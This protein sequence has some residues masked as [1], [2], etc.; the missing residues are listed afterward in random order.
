MGEHT[1]WLD[2]LPGFD[3]LQN[4]MKI[5]FGRTWSNSMFPP[6]KHFTIVPVFMS[7]IVF[8]IILAVS[9]AYR[10]SSENSKKLTP[11]TRISFISVT[12]LIIYNLRIIT[13]DI[14]GDEKLTKDIFP[15]I[16][17]LFLFILVGNFIGLIPGFMPPGSTLQLNLAMALTVFIFTHYLGIRK[18]GFRYMKQFTG[19]YPLLA[20]LMIPIEIL[21]HLSRPLS[22][23]MRLLGN[24]FADHKVLSIFTFIFPLIVPIPFIFL[25]VLVSLIQALVFT[26]LSVIYFT[27][28]CSD[29]H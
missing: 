18:H 6:Q 29:E 22:L 7:L 21:S 3:T 2:F 24:M 11:S 1:T 8:L 5:Y 4:F 23:T 12:D 27:L 16:T 25:G 9:I 13:N 26:L 20:P 19:S 28:A 17:T 10:K 14:T 15:L